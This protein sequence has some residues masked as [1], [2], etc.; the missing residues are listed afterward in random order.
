MSCKNKIKIIDNTNI[1][2]SFF[3]TLCAYPLVS[4]DD[5]VHHKD[6]NACHNCF[7][8]FIESRKKEWQE[9]WRPLKEDFKEYLKTRKI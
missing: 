1:E 3:C 2:E 6:W 9:G 8:Q 5:F 7:L 4:Y